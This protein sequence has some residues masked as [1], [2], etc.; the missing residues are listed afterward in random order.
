MKL[1]NIIS[2]AFLCCALSSVAQTNNDPIVMT[3][4]GVPVTRS[5]FEYSYNKNNSEGVIDKKTV[6]E[7]VDLFVNYKLKVTA[8]LDEKMDTLSSFKEEF[9]NYRDQQIRPAM[10][11]ETDVEN[12]AYKIYKDTQFK[13]DSMGGIVKPAHILIFARQTATDEQ[14]AAAKA[15]IDSIYSVLK[16]ANFDS[17]VFG[18]L[19]VKHSDDKGS[20]K[21]AGELPWIHKGQTLPEFDDKVFAMLVGETSEPFKT[22]AGFHIVQ[23]RG[24]DNYFPYDSVRTDILRY[25]EQRGIRNQIINER[26]DSLSKV[27]GPNVT[28]D[29]ILARK[30]EQMVASDP[31]LKNLIQEYHDGLLLYEISNRLVWDKAAKDEEG[32]AK[33]FKKNKKKYAWDEP[34]FKGIAYRTKELADVEAVKACVKGLAFEDWNEKLRSTFNN[35]S[36]LRIRVEKGVF[37]KGDN[38]IIDTYEYKTDATIKPI[39]GYPNTASFGKMIKAPENYADVRGLVVADYQEK[40]EAEW[41]AELRKKYTVIVNRDVLATVNQHQ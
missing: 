31:E 5:E 16:A 40:L 30:R 41:I 20:M 11:T 34:R 4:N 21:S 17:A 32:L 18:E 26:L 33:F 15:R 9:A 6:D 7:Y 8:A 19:A 35:D 39:K 22:N 38:A 27:A 13:V 3:I 24:K 25:I 2:V 36:V 28:P 14:V 23:L 37:K 12:R 10:I 1:R 29:D